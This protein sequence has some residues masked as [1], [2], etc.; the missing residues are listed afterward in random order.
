MIIHLGIRYMLV[1]MDTM[2]SPVELE[3]VEYTVNVKG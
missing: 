1:D 3:S 2:L